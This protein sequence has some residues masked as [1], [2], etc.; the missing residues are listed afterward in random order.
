MCDDARMTG[1]RDP[2]SP[3]SSSSV[4]R[5]A[6]A[7]LLGVAAMLAGCTADGGGSSAGAGP[8]PGSTLPPQ[9][10]VDGRPVALINGAGVPWS[11]LRPRLLESA[12]AEVLA[13]WILD[14]RLTAAL[15]DAGIRIAPR[16]LE[17]EQDRLLDR[18]AEDPGEAARLLAELRDSRNLGPVRFEAL[19]RRN[20]GLR[21]LVA[22]RVIV[23]EA[24][25]RAAFDVAH[26]PRRQVRLMTLSDL[27]TAS[28]VRAELLA[29]DRP[30]A[31]VATER[32]T[33]LSAARGG[34]LDAFSEL[35]PGLPDVIRRAA[36]TLESPG[37]ISPPVLL[38]DGAA[39]LQLVRIVPADE[40]TREAGRPDAERAA[41][42]SAE[43]VAMER[44]ARDLV[45]GSAVTVLDPSLRDA[46]ERR[47]RRQAS[48][49]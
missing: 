32:S 26:G 49:R 4:G 46:W 9:V 39:L 38:P 42:L 10:S 35:D 22:D 14:Q 33:D 16:M 15:L 41:R 19:L 28:R 47:R 3:R 24:Q 40:V 44:L 23:T 7:A 37:D 17:V 12:G 21:A 48:P 18:L 34:L 13:D 30:F 11:E 36:F 6:A 27:A 20:A 8:G 31:E 1:P 2:A 43:R 25:I 45:Q 5:L 29:G